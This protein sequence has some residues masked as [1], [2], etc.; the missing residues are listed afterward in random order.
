MHPPITK[1]RDLKQQLDEKRADAS[2]KY[3]A[4]DNA[5]RKAIEA[6]VDLTKDEK[7][8][9]ELEQ[10]HQTYT[11]AA[12]DTRRLE[13]DLFRALDHPG[14][15]A[16]R[17]G[18]IGAEFLKRL[19]AGGLGL[20]ALDGTSGGSLVPP[21]F[22]ELIR[23]LPQRQLFARTLI[24]VRQADGDKVWYLRETVFTNQAAPVAAGAEKPRSTITVER[25]EETVRTIAHVTE[26]LDRALLSD[27]DELVTFLDT[28]LV[29]GVLLA[30]ENQILN[31][32]G[33]A[34]N[35]RGI[36]NTVG[37]G[38]VVKGGAEPA[39]DAIYRGITSCRLAFFEPTGIV[40]HPNDWRDIRL[41]KDA[42][43]QYLGA[44][45]IEGDP[46]TLFGKPVITSPV[47]AEG[48]GL[49]GDFENGAILWDREEARVTFTEA[50]LGDAAGQELFTRNLIRF[51]GEERI[52][53]GVPRPAA[54]TAVTGL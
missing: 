53:F 12:D 45:M 20:K 50:G 36:L 19:G 40:L 29:L 48:T 42:N 26:A 30:E 14:K 24:P 27:F 1:A 39:V 16:L 11:A 52:A 54:F 22:D 2:V 28:Q 3:Q 7:V 44:E 10:L 15:Q 21:F 51:R 33:V 23:E 47:I 38:A 25:I 5:R 6:G 37:I 41:A 49:V 35:L 34:P 4:F 46:E 32:S 43:G 8:K 31:G 9:T 17:A 13:D 18:R